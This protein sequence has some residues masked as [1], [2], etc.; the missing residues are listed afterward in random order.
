MVQTA[1]VVT[2]AGAATRAVLADAAPVSP[3]AASPVT[4][5]TIAVT[6]PNACLIF[7]IALVSLVWSWPLTR[8]I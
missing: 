3:S 7:M 8:T 5:A 2:N 6:R 1:T 4:V